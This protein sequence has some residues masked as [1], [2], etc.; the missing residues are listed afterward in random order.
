MEVRPLAGA[1]GAEIFGIDLRHGGDERTWSELHRVF[2]EERVVAIR[3]QDL[4]LDDM[5][6]IGRRFGEPCFY[7]FARGMEDYP[8][9][10]Q[11]VKEVGET[12]NFGSDWHSDTTYLEQPPAATLLY[13]IETPP[14]GGDTLYANTTA[15]YD[16]LSDGMKQMIGGLVGVFSGSLKRKRAGGRAEHHRGIAGMAVQNAANAAALEAKHPVVRTHPETGRKALYL[17]SLHTIRFDGMT[18]EE[19]RPLIDYLSAHCVKP[20]F[21]CRVH[22]QPGTLTVWDNRCTMHKANP[23]YPAGERREMHRIVIEG[24]VPV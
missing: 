14:R 12:E 18:E 16:A 24:T 21:T 5:M 15:A 23:D 8:Y 4:S 9:I 1:L 11:V 7:P 3:G 22:W 2:L 13:A 19:S 6:A 17:T 10:T 20:E